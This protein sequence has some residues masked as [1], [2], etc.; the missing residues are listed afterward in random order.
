MDHLDIVLIVNF[1]FHLILMIYSHVLYDGSLIVVVPIRSTIYLF[2][3]F[4][5]FQ[6]FMAKKNKGKTRK[7]KIN[8]LK[9]E[10]ENR[11]FVFYK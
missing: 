3:I 9:R 4:A 2:T 8:E 5:F 10:K 7:T 6:L 11:N 1:Q